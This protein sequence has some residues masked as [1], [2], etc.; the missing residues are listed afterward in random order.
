MEKFIEE[1]IESTFAFTN[2]QVDNIR[3]SKDFNKN[4][5]AKMLYAQCE[6]YQIII[7]NI[8]KNDTKNI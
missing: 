2:N 6:I 7:S 1:H 4:Y 8:I 5:T 3:N